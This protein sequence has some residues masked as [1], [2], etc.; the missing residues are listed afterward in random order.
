MNITIT[1]AEPVLAEDAVQLDVLAQQLETECDI[2]VTLIKQPPQPGR[3]DGG[4]TIALSL[5]S[6]ATSGVSAVI[7]LLA[8]WQSQ[9]ERYSITIT[10]G[11]HAFSINNLSRDQ[12]E[13]KLAELMVNAFTDI[14]VQIDHD[15]SPTT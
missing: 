1:L 2:P 4:L 3:K 6:L 7:A 9:Q 5:L 10:Q 8:Y 13:R 15:S 14:Q 11:Q 12:L